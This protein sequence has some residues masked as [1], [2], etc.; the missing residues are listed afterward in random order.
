LVVGVAELFVLDGVV[1]GVATVVGDFTVLEGTEIGFVA[2]VLDNLGC[3]G[4]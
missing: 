3:L 1:V 4:Q 2:G